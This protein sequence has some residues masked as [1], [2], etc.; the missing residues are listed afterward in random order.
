MCGIYHCICGASP[1][2]D[3]LLLLLL[4]FH[5]PHTPKAFAY[6]LIRATCECVWHFYVPPEICATRVSKPS[7]VIHLRNIPIESSE[8]DVISLGVPFG[9]VT[10]VLVLKGKNQAFLEMADE[11]SATSM[12]SCY[13]VTP[14]HMR[15]RMVYVQYSNHRELK[16]DQSHNNVSNHNHLISSGILLIPLTNPNA[17]VCDF[18]MY[19]LVP[20]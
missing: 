3:Q 20:G 18:C 2:N 9:R 17:S 19:I 4:Q 15:G 12:V 13:T 11:I 6:Q 7:K 10:N 1:N 8:S 14:P 5:L 16:T